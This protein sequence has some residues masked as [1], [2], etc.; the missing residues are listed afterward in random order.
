MSSVACCVLLSDG[1]G[2]FGEFALVVFHSKLTRFLRDE[3]ATARI[4]AVVV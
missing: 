3:I 4:R 1:C 2:S